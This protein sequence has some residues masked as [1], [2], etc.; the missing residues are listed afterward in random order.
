M[1]PFACYGFFYYGFILNSL[2]HWYQVSVSFV[3]HKSDYL[4]NNILF[5]TKFKI[6]QYYLSQKKKHT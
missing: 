6:K 4:L 5:L 1:T 2:Y 3:K